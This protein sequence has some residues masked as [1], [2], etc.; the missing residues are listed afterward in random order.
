M[1]GKALA[2][3]DAHPYEVGR[4]LDIRLPTSDIHGWSLKLHSRISP[5]DGWALE[6]R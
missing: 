5:Y 2:L 1:S 6:A 3:C 4:R